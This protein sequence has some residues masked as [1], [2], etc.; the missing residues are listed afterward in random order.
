MVVMIRCPWKLG[1]PFPGKGKIH[2]HFGLPEGQK[3]KVNARIS[4]CL[5]SCVCVVVGVVGFLSRC[6][7]VGLWSELSCCGLHS[8]TK[9]EGD[10]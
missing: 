9:R 5:V 4:H 8:Y 7:G 1:S 6:V 3:R 10:C 2:E